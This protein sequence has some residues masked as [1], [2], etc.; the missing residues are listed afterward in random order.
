MK[1]ELWTLFKLCKELALHMDL[2]YFPYRLSHS[3]GKRKIDELADIETKNSRF[4]GTG[5][6]ICLQLTSAVKLT[7]K[8]SSTGCGL[9]C[10][11]AQVPVR[12]YW[13]AVVLNTLWS[14]NCAC[15]ELPR[16][17]PVFTA[18]FSSMKKR[19]QTELITTVT[20]EELRYMMMMMMMM[21][22]IRKV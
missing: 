21:T 3:S 13:T 9:I 12:V 14:A 16:P 19:N 5:F 7:S 18:G 4:D 1:C 6:F 8:P 20:S 11:P 22:L 17:F 2:H 15:P 10:I